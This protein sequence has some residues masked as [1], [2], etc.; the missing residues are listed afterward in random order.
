MCF[1][2]PDAQILGLVTFC[3]WFLVVHGHEGENWKV[4]DETYKSLFL[5][6]VSRDAGGSTGSLAFLQHLAALLWPLL[7]K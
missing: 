2:E 1:T 5:I 6:S 7:L 4:S 3:W